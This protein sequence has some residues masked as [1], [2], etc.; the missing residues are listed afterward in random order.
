M[1]RYVLAD[2]KGAILAVADADV[3]PEGAESPFG[4]PFAGQQVV[5]LTGDQLTA[6]QGLEPHEVLEQYTL[7]P[8]KQTLVKKG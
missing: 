8:K 3:M 7:D 5:E 4:P 1:G 2:T 6:V